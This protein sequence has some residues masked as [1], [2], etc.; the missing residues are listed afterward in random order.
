MV[1]VGLG[2]FFILFSDQVIGASLN[3]WILPLILLI[4]FFLHFWIFRSNKKATMA[5]KRCLRIFWTR[6]C[7]CFYYQIMSEG[8]QFAARKWYFS[9]EE[10]ENSPSRKDDIDPKSES[11]LRKLYCSFLHEIGVKLKVWVQVIPLLSNSILS[12]IAR[13]SRN[14]SWVFIGLLLDW[15]TCCYVVNSGLVEIFYWSGQDKILFA[16]AIYYLSNQYSI[17]GVHLKGKKTVNNRFLI[18]SSWLV[19]QN[20][21]SQSF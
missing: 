20:F 13:K 9:K 14:D 19:L 2:S 8:S 11:Q 1:V 12:V 18:V 5:G 10:I 21:V 17:L 4:T 3:S 15:I 7:E 6:N 16:F